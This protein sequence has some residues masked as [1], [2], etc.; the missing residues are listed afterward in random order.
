MSIFPSFNHEPRVPHNDLSN[1][2][3]RLI[4]FASIVKNIH[5]TSISSAASDFISLGE[6]CKRKKIYWVFNFFFQWKIFANRVQCT[7]FDNSAQYSRY[8]I[9]IFLHIIVLS[10]VLLILWSILSIWILFCKTF[11]Q[12]NTFL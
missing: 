6:L 7:I 1:T 9:K 2:S 4:D 11:M 12:H 5:I 3:Y 10:I 8:Y